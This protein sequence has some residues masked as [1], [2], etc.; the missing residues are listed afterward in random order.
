MAPSFLLVLA[1]PLLTVGLIAEDLF[2]NAEMEGATEVCWSGARERDG[3][4]STW[5]DWR[6]QEEKDGA[7]D[8]R[9][10]HIAVPAFLFS[11]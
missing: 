10:L 2:A 9:R 1:L 5:I 11:S 3:G 4:S 6:I 7:A 8:W